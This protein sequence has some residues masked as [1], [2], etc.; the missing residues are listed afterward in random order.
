M[1]DKYDVNRLAIIDFDVHHGNGTQHTFDRDPT[2]LYTSLHR[3]PFF[4]GT[5]DRDETGSGP[6]IGTKFNYPLEVGTGDD[7]YLDILRNSIPDKVLE[8]QPEFILL[9]TGF[10]AHIL[11]PIGGMRVT[12]ETFGEISRVLVS[13][14][15]EC[16]QGKVLSI[17]EADIIWMDWPIVSKFIWKHCWMLNHFT[18]P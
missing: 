14:A 1:K 5:G 6:G 15:G 13:L 4:P 16:C 2:V 11:D 3:Y 18:E 12:T 8:F 9:S 17:L 10:D 7:V